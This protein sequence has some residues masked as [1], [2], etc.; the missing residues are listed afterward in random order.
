MPAVSSPEAVPT[1]V[2]VNRR[3]WASLVKLASAVPTR[4]RPSESDFGGNV[5]IATSVEI[6]W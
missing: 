1:H 2:G 4:S 3:S 6:G 5:S